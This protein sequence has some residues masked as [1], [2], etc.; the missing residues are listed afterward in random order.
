MLCLG[1][2]CKTSSESQ[3]RARTGNGGSMCSTKNLPANEYRESKAKRRLVV[4]E[5]LCST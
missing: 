3:R 2:A 5:A 1:V 4:E